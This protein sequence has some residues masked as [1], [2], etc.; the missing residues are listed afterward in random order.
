MSQHVLRHLLVAIQRPGE[1]HRPVQRAFRAAGWD[2][3]LVHPFASKQ[4]RQPAD[5]DNKTDDADLGGIF[6]AAVNGFGLLQP[7]WPDVYLELQPLSRQ[8]RD[9]VCKTT[10][11]RCQIK[12]TLHQLMPGYAEL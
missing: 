10:I 9:L 8:R 2:T 6:R 12:E 1:Y 3:R 4:F 11:L 7:L 5:P